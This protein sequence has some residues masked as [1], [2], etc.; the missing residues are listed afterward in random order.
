MRTIPPER[1]FFSVAVSWALTTTTPTDSINVDR[2][3][4]LRISSVIPGKLQ[5]WLGLDITHLLH[6]SDRRL[7]GLPKTGDH[8]SKTEKPFGVIV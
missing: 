2:A 1:G 8:L 4:R 6:K 5:D 7:A 3:I